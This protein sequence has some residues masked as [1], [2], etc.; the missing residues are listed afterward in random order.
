MIPGINPSEIPRTKYKMEIIRE[1]TEVKILKFELK[2]FLTVFK[3]IIHF[4]N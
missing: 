2:N 3:F 4:Q 1:I